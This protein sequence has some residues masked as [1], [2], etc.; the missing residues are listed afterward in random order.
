[1]LIWI[2]TSCGQYCSK[3][4]WPSLIWR[5]RQPRLSLPHFRAPSLPDPQQHSSKLIIL[6]VCAN[7]FHSGTFNRP[8]LPLEVYKIHQQSSFTVHPYFAAKSRSYLRGLYL[9]RTSDVNLSP[10]QAPNIKIMFKRDSTSRAQTRLSVAGDRG[11]TNT[12]R[13]NM[14]AKQLLKALDLLL[15]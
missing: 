3:T 2:I 12:C 1:M 11:C 8:S 9:R 15:E 7:P 14:S 4:K 13:I 5:H 6:S 10:T